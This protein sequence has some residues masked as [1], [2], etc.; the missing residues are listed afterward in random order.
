MKNYVQANISDKSSTTIKYAMKMLS[1]CAET[2]IFICLGVNT[3][4]DQHEWVNRKLVE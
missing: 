4:S 3:V 2:I 1:S